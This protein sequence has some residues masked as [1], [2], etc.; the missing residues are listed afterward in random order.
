MVLH[1]GTVDWLPYEAWRRL[2]EPWAVARRSS[3]RFST[4]GFLAVTA[5]LAGGFYR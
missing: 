1:L 5:A 3:D 4:S 2:A